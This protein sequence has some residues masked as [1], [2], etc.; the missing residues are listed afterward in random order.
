MNTLS[1]FFSS[2]PYAP[3][4]ERTYLDILSRFLEEIPDPPNLTA[5]DLLD[6]IRRP[7]WGGA[8]QAVALAACKKY[9]AWRYGQ[10]HAALSARMK[11]P[12]PKPQRALTAQTALHLLASHDPHAPKGARD[13]AMS[14]LMLD[15]GLRA[16]EVC[17][18]QQA[19]TDTE[20]RTLQVIVKGGQW[21]A[22]VFSDETAAH[23][24]RWKSYRQTITKCGNLF[25]S[26]RT[27][28]S[29]TPEGLYK[30]V[31]DW[32]NRIDVKLSPH[33]LRR[34]F[35]TL[36]TLAG[37]PE[38]VLMEGGRWSSSSMIHRYTRTLQLDAMRVY[39]PVA[40]LKA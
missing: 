9:L 11:R 34:S 38:R 25:C 28:S 24:E 19:D 40:N 37:A 12:Q 32:G 35:A 14:A 1:D 36:A 26:T 39:L 27:G 10:N 16:A 21:K 20:R 13:L 15:T 5:S 23:I 7:S 17:R 8:R 3:T 29:L 18:L 4:T 2:C 33:D 30:I 22:A 6:F 31:S